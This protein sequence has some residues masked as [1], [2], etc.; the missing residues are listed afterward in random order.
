M[1]P[2]QWSPF[3][4]FQMDSIECT[5]ILH[6]ICH[7]LSPEGT[8]DAGRFFCAIVVVGNGIA[9]LCIDKDSTLRL[10]EN[11]EVVGPTFD[12]EWVVYGGIV[13]LSG[14]RYCTFTRYAVSGSV[15][16]LVTGRLRNSFYI[17]VAVNTRQG[18]VHAT[19]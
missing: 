13:G 5:V 10:L 15:P 9:V 12:S 2:P 1:D 8:A 6:S 4:G 11:A 7:P 17:S 16:T 3:S 19:S 14:G 18:R